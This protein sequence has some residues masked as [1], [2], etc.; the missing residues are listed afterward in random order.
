MS[1][2]LT[3]FHNLAGRPVLRIDRRTE[4][5]LHVNHDAGEAWQ[6]EAAIRWWTMRGCPED[7]E[8]HKEGN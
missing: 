6:E 5:A 2:R 1:E 7:Y 8:Y 3:T 4:N